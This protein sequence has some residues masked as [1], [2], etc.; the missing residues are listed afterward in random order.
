MGDIDGDGRVDLIGV[1]PYVNDPQNIEDYPTHLTPWLAFDNGQ[2]LPGVASAVDASAIAD[3][4]TTRAVAGDVDLDGKLDLM[5]VNAGLNNVAIHYGDQ[6][7][8]F[9]DGR[10]FS[11]VSPGVRATVLGQLNPDEDEFMTWFPWEQVMCLSRT[12]GSMRKE[13][14]WTPCDPGLCGFTTHGGCDH[15]Y[16]SGWV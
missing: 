1:T 12:G 7:G 9:T 13:D 15:G 4:D 3:P 11:A 10:L 5:S 2:W 16:Q 8:N 14:D 6:I